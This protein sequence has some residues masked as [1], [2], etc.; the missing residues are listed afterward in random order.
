M[1]ILKISEEYAEK[2]GFK[3][4]P[5][6]K[7][8][9]MIIKGLKKNQEKYG[10]QFCPCRVV[11]GDFEKDREIICPCVFHKDEIKKW[12]HCLCKLFFSA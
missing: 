5:D 3:L 10:Y 4:N 7:Q 1:K 8:L 2:A 11:T 9:N 12:G 6:K